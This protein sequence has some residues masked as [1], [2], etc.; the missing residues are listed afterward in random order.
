MKKLFLA[1]VFAALALFGAPL[2]A[3]QQPPQGTGENYEVRLTT[4][5]DQLRAQDGRIEQLEFENRNLTQTLQRLQS[6]SDQRFSKLESGSPSP[7]ATAAPLQQPPAVAAPIAPAGT[8]VSGTTT[9]PVT[10][11]ESAPVKGTLGSLTVQDGKVTGAIDN[12]Q[13]PALPNK[14]E[15]YGL[16]PK[17]QYD[18]AFGLLRQAN[19]DE[20]EKAFKNFIDKNPKDKLLDNA[21]YWYGETLYVR[22]R[23]DESAVAFA[24]AYQQNPQGSKAPDSLL[25]LAMSLANINKVPDACTTLAELKTKFPTASTA[26]RGRADEERSKLQCKAH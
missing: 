26:V 23:F 8:G 17:E 12:P 21:K 19:Y 22:G 5:E 14:P 10:M 11:P 13:T 4:L 16:T 2:Y 15:D 18:R 6:D 20:A 1:S 3:Q 24:E 7:T 25:K 9:V